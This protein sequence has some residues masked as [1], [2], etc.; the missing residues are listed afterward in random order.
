M[1][2]KPIDEN[3]NKANVNLGA[4]ATVNPNVSNI[5]ANT[6]DAAKIS[7]TR[8]R[9]KAAQGTVD[10]RSTVQYQLEQLMQGDPGVGGWC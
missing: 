2:Y 7:R 8:H 9:W 10:P 3:A 6:Y 1:T 4:A 5:N